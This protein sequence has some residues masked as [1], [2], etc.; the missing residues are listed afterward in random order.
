MNCAPICLRAVVPPARAR[1]G[2]RGK[3][4]DIRMHVII[5]PRGGDFCYSDTEFEAMKIDV[6]FCKQVGADGVVIGVLNPDGTVDAERTDALIKLARPLSITFH[7]AF[8]VTR[9]PFEALEML[10]GLGVDRILTSGQESSA[11]EGLDLITEL[12]KRAGDRLVIMPGGGINE[13][14]VGRIVAA[15]GARE[16]HLHAGKALDGQMRYRNPRVYMGGQLRPPEHSV[17][18]TDPKRIRTIVRG[19]S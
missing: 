14:N 3:L 16:V 8:D 1:S 17:T 10:I 7:R 19:L 15:S 2:W 6:E 13:R 18:T 9:D 4:L 5:R 12:V 11:L